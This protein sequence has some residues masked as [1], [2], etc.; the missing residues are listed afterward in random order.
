[1]RPTSSPT[2]TRTKNRRINSAMLCQLSYRGL[3]EQRAHFTKGWPR[4]K[5]RGAAGSIRRQPAPAIGNSGVW[6]RAGRG[7]LFFDGLGYQSPEFPL[8]R[9]SRRSSTLQHRRPTQGTVRS[10]I[11]E[12]GRRNTAD[13][14]EGGL[15]TTKLLN[16]QQE[17][18]SRGLRR[19][20]Y[21]G[22]HARTPAYAE[23]RERARAL[24]GD[25]QQLPAH[26]EVPR[27]SP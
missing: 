27:P 6:S 26:D 5:S 1:M 17:G 21:E 13:R 16:F 9:A 3:L 2:W 11:Q 23:R 10:E 15:V 25:V 4:A 12:V 20:A 18:R 24:V 14:P 8:G 19:L 22:R 7:S